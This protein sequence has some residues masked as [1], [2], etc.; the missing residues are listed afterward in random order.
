MRSLI[1]EVDEP[2]PELDLGRRALVLEDDHVLQDHRTVPQFPRDA[3]VVLPKK[4]LLCSLSYVKRNDVDGYVTKC[5]N[6]LALSK[7]C[8]YTVT[9]SE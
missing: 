5:C 4:V 6:T 7:E 2:G 8:R 9:G 1:V 3:R